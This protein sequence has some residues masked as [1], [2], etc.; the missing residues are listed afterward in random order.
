MNETERSFHDAMIDVYVRAKREC[1]YNATRFLQMVTQSG[2]L[3]TAHKLLAPNEV[4]Y[5]FT[6]LWEHKRLDLTV[7]SL[8]LQDRWRGFF[9][10]DELAVARLR[11]R[12]HGE[13]V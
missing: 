8:V 10:K 12:A 2:G 7:E 1:G 9:T 6:E 3:A 13:P 5:G 4:Q 11:L